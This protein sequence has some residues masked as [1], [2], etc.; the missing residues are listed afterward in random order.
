[1]GNISLGIGAPLIGAS[2]AR[3]NVLTFDVYTIHPLH[4]ANLAEKGVRFDVFLFF[5]LVFFVHFPLYKI[6]VGV[7]MNMDL[8]WI[9]DPFPPPHCDFTGMA[10]CAVPQSLPKKSSLGEILKRKKIVI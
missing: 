1:M 3:A 7:G 6:T 5:V 8:N 4:S 10:L 2:Y 9:H